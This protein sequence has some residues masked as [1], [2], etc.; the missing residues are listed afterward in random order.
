MGTARGKPNITYIIF[1]QKF[2]LS[3][4]V[5][6]HILVKMFSS[7]VFREEL[8]PCGEVMQMHAGSQR[9]LPFFPE[10]LHWFSHSPTR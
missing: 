8:R 1:F 7:R 2:Y 9:S 5:Q 6:A 10:V 3:G 4:L